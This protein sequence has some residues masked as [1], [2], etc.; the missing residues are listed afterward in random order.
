VL[1]K[2]R[3]WLAALMLFAFGIAIEFIQ[4][5]VGREA[6]VEDVLA[7]TAGI[8]IAWCAVALWRRV[9]MRRRLTSTR[10]DW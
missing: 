7:N 9:S 3:L 5:S 1:A 4:P 2:L 6:H 8:L 10:V